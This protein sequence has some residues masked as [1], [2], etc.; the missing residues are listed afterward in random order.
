[1]YCSLSHALPANPL[2]AFARSGAAT[3]RLRD[4]Q[5]RVIPHFLGRLETTLETF[6][7]WADSPCPAI[8]AQ[9]ADRGESKKNVNRLIGKMV[10]GA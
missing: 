6:F 3:G 4:Q 7:Q 1:M 10:Y 9:K 8:K 2:V 5:P